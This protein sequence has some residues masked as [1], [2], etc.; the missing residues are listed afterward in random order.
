[1]PIFFSFQKGSLLIF[2][3]LYV[4]LMVVVFLACSW[5]DPPLPLDRQKFGPKAGA[6]GHATLLGDLS[7][8][9]SFCDPDNESQIMIELL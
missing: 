2:I 5:N 3:F 9:L 6:T 7:A 4:E 1:M 8:I